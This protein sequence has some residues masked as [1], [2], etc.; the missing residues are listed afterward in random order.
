MTTPLSVMQGMVETAGQMPQTYYTIPSKEK[1]FEPGTAALAGMQAAQPFALQIEK[2]D[3]SEQA[4]V[5]Q[6]LIDEGIGGMETFAKS[7]TDPD[8]QN[9][10]LSQIGTIKKISLSVGPEGTQKLVTEFYSSVAS[11]MKEKEKSRLKELELSGKP[12]EPKT[13][14]EQITLAADKAAATAAGAGEGKPPKPPTATQ[15]NAANFKKSYPVLLNEIVKLASNR[16]TI[17]EKTA[18]G[19]DK[20]PQLVESTNELNA[21]EEKE[22]TGPLKWKDRKR[23]AELK[24]FIPAAKN[25]KYTGDFQK[26]LDK[27]DADVKKKIERLQAQASRYGILNLPSYDLLIANPEKAKAVYEST[28]NSSLAGINPEEEVVEGGAIAPEG[29]LKDI[30]GLTPVEQRLIKAIRAMKDP[31]EKQKA[32]AALEAK[33]AELKDYF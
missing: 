2:M 19:K 11:A 30:S 13:R 17:S 7:L 5:M 1:K 22:K 27:Y 9:L 18:E 10:A 31:A 29:T 3:R 23:L 25:S 15:I 14:E 32:I 20:Y 24:S 6:K 33:K 21:L 4:S 28:I 12:W 16:P 8:I 26:N